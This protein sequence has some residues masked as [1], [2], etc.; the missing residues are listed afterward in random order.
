MQMTQIYSCARKM[1]D[2]LMRI[3]SLVA[4]VNTLGSNNALV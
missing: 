4:A 1:S 2:T 3:D